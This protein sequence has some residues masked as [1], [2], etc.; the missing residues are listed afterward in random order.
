MEIF[1]KKRD[2]KEIICIFFFE[3][4]IKSRLKINSIKLD[5]KLLLFQKNRNIIYYIKRVLFGGNYV[6]EAI[7]EMYLYKTK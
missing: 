6:M 2:A 5:T 3:R 4:K 7:N 1:P